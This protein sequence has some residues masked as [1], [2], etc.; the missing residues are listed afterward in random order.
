MA[1]EKKRVKEGKREEE[2][3]TRQELQESTG[4]GTMERMNYGQLRCGAGDPVRQ[5][6]RIRF[7]GGSAR[8]TAERSRATGKKARR[9]DG[10]EVDGN[11]HLAP[12][13]GAHACFRGAGGHSAGARSL[14]SSDVGVVGS[15]VSCCPSASGAED[16]D[17]AGEERA[18]SGAGDGVVV[19]IGGSAGT[20]RT[21]PAAAAAAVELIWRA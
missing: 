4:H 17:E 2:K 11:F 5:P 8:N 9:A 10:A 12:G 20:G 1:V 18:G 7:L 16:D 13:G 6:A 21:S 3:V 14:L 19:L 15:S